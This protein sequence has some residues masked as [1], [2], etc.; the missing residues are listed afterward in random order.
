ER[1]RAIRVELE[2][3]IVELEARRAQVA[4]DAVAPMLRVAEHADVPF[5]GIARHARAQRIEVHVGRVGPLPVMACVLLQRG[6]RLGCAVRPAA[7]TGDVALP[8]VAGPAMLELEPAGVRLIA[9]RSLEP[10]ALEAAIDRGRRRTDRRLAVTE[11]ALEARD[12][13]VRQRRDDEV[14][15]I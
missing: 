5:R 15:M 9:Q 13:E 4:A 2:A 7:E 14:L 10:G 8:R 12:R 3:G 11:I 6:D 1:H